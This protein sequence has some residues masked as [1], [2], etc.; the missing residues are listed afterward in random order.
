MEAG[1]RD[2]VRLRP[3]VMFVKMDQWAGP[4]TAR[5]FLLGTANSR[6]QT[7]IDVQY[8]VS[9]VEMIG[10]APIEGLQATTLYDAA[11][12]IVL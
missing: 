4:G 12:G 2:A 5:G 1:E 9:G 10:V 7:Y 3:N 6:L 8:L 11:T